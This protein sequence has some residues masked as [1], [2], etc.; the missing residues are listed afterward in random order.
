MELRAPCWRWVWAVLVTVMLAGLL[1]FA[2]PAGAATDTVTLV[3][4]DTL[5][6]A[7]ESDTVEVAVHRT[8][9]TDQISVDWELQLAGQPVPAGDFTG[10]TS[11][12]LI[13]AAGVTLDQT[14]TLTVLDDLVGE[15][16]ETFT[17]V[18]DNP[19]N[20]G[21]PADA[22]AIV[23]GERDVR[24]TDDGD[25]GTIDISA[26]A[27]V[28]ETDI[29]QPVNVTVT[30]SGGSEG[31]ASATV[32]SSRP[33][34]LTITGG[35]AIWDAGQSGA[36]T[37]AA[38][39]VGDNVIESDEAVDLT[40]GSSSGATQGT[41]ASLTIVDDDSGGQLRF[42]AGLPATV[43]ETDATQALTV[44]VERIGDTAGGAG[45][46]VTSDRPGDLAVVNGNVSWSAG[47]GGSRTVDLQL[48]GDDLDENAESTFLQLG[49]VSGAATLGS[50]AAS[51]T[52]IIDDDFVP[53]AADDSFTTAEDTPLTR[54]AATGLRQNDSDGDT[55]VGSLT[56]SAAAFV[57]ATLGSVTVSLD[58][59]FTFTPAANQ[60]GSGSF[61]Y[62][63]SDGTNTD[64]ATVS[65]TVAGSNDAPAATNDQYGTAED[66]VLSV[67][68]ASGVLANDTDPDGDPLTA[69]LAAAF[70]PAELGTV[71]LDGDGSFVFTPALDRSGSGTFSYT[72]SDGTATDT[73]TVT[74]NVAA[75]N[76]PP[77][78]VDDTYTIPEDTVLVVSADQGLLDNDT[79]PED[80]PLNVASFGGVVPVQAGEVQVILGTG[81][82]T[83]TPAA[84]YIGPATFSYTV[85][86][87]ART[88]TGQA[89]ITVT[90]VND[91][92]VA[93]ADGYSTSEDTELWLTV[94]ADSPLANDKDVEGDPLTV[95]LAATSDQGSTVTQLNPDGRF[96]YTPPLNFTGTDRIA[97][98]LSDGTLTD[99][100][101]ITIDVG[102]SND[103]PAAPALSVW[104]VRSSPT[105]IDLASRVT[106][107]DGD[108]VTLT[109]L[110]GPVLVGATFACTGLRCTYDPPANLVSIDTVT[111]QTS[112]GNGGL[113]TGTLTLYVGFPR[114]SLFGGRGCEI[115]L[116]AGKGPNG[117]AAGN[118]ICGTAGDDVIDGGAGDDW[119]VGLGGNDRLDGGPGA[120][121]LSGGPGEDV[122][123]PG[124]GSD[125]TLGGTGFDLVRYPGTAADETIVVS[126]GAATLVSGESRHVAT[127]VV[128]VGAAGGADTVNVVP[129][130]G[131]AFALAGGN[132]FDRLIYDTA[133]QSGVR[134]EGN[135]IVADN[136]LP[137]NFSGFE[138][139]NLGS[140]YVPGT[141]GRDVIR[142]L[143]S[144]PAGLQIDLLGSGDDLT[145]DFGRLAGPV[146]VSDSGASGQDEL[147][148]LGT[149]GADVVMLTPTA[150]RRGREHVSFR[151]QEVVRLEGGGGSDVL[152]VAAT[153]G[154][155][156]AAVR[157]VAI[158]G[159]Q[160]FDRL[161]V[162]TNGSV[163]PSRLDGRVLVSGHAPIA[164]TG[165][166]AIELRCPA[167]T[168][169]VS[170]VDGYWVASSSGSVTAFGEV[171]S[172]G[173]WASPG[174]P[175]GA[176]ASNPD[177][178]GYWVALRNGDVTPFGG[179]KAHG[180]V[181]D[182]LP[183]GVTLDAPIVSMSSSR[184]G[185]GYYLLGRDGGVFSFGDATFYGSTG[186]IPLAAPVVAMAAN[187]A[188]RGYWYVSSDG[189]IFAYGSDT[190]FWGSVPGV[191]PPGRSL[192]A[193]IVG[194]APTA[195]GRGYWLVASDG[196]IFTFGDARFLGSVPGVLTPLGQ[197]LASPIVGMVAT[198]T[199][200]G[201]WLVA[202]DGGVFNFGD[203]AFFGSSG[204]QG[205]SD[206]VG[207]AG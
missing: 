26:P 111:Y 67:D 24:V 87:G 121:V 89:T 198:A 98:T 101:E 202:S 6:E 36:R 107:P 50:P 61:T 72:V 173:G 132:G 123:E 4:G 151:D 130:A 99:A 144:S 21:V 106:D 119:I 103:A 164:P 116:R 57:P 158:D 93:V 136:R 195:T 134:R 27:T 182:R 177:K 73:A 122:L 102:G 18:L 34:D 128:E 171:D 19:Q 53:N 117:T 183:A 175:V 8:D 77:L 170:L 32:V 68:A 81:G 174:V 47:Q 2:G 156:A 37:V 82:F 180:S 16:V 188:G 70:S 15:P 85:S 141:S 43:T 52:Q 9:G 3:D 86:D 96:R 155:A 23:D 165:I 131:V 169:I 140:F 59:A 63:L 129:A 178:S 95:D 55:P 205:H 46:V 66:A 114:T 159:G 203:A 196:G 91:A 109:V 139:V 40:F 78:A 167:S 135:R 186:G 92:P 83:F 162:T 88:A 62:T 197:K 33:E 157:V 44:T 56:V 28:N 172:L 48:I 69:T 108:T 100:G 145:V 45:A 90:A 185:K 41:T 115:D 30:R 166:E 138:V 179:A 191:L 110:S 126:G 127:E 187:P 147:T 79:D 146:S 190:R 104:P 12:T 35:A 125:E 1:P 76:D 200:R 199:G 207:L 42:S 120:D 58:G 64:V 168:R 22:V 13:W 39:L 80:A 160:G 189:G 65:I 94:A 118:V 49:I 133:G 193:P 137:V 38:N 153:T 192:D 206:I 143:G 149:A 29:G 97:Y 161:V 17:V 201:Y 204:G 10:P 194:M 14:I 142:F 124:G 71:D 105:V 112:D 7:L 154:A 84:D 181:R 152:T 176:I 54:S 25:A 31:G 60:T 150:A 5:V 163:C 51:P 75:V 11:G 113:A 20:L 74:I 148:M 184:T